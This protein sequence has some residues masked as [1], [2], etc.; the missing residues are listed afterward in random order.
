MDHMD[1]AMQL[2]TQSPSSESLG[3]VANDTGAIAVQAQARH[4]LYGPCPGGIAERFAGVPPGIRLLNAIQTVYKPVRVRCLFFVAETSE[5]SLAPDGL[6]QRGQEITIDDYE[7]SICDCGYVDQCR[8]APWGR[9]SPPSSSTALSTAGSQQWG[10]YPIRL[11]SFAQLSTAIYRASSNNPDNE[12]VQRTLENGVEVDTYPWDLPD[13]VAVWL[14]DFHNDWHN[15]AAI[16]F[17]QTIEDMPT[18]A[19]AWDGYA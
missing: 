4:R 19:A 7:V 16:S 11:L 12:N 18:I 10:N 15:G 3:S 1:E 17:M 14:R 5:R 6:N 8:G 13:E 2:S 9:G